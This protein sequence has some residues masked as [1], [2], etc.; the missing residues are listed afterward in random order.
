MPIDLV[1][2]FRAPEFIDEVVDE[3]IAPKVKSIWIQEDIVNEPA[4][5]RAR[6]SG[7]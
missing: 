7:A 1:N 4:A 5:R 3:C 6:A 2:V